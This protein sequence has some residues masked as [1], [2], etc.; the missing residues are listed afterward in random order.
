M[1]EH[2]LA[3]RIEQLEADNA[4]LRHLLARQDVGMELRHQVRNTLATVRA[5]IRRSAEIDGTVDDYAAHLEGRLDAILRV[6]GTM[7]RGAIEG[8]DLYGL[9]SSELLA[10]LAQDGKQVRIE[11]PRLHLQ[12][13][14]AEPLC[15]AF[16]EL[17]T[18][19]VKFGVLGVPD[20]H[21]DVIWGV[22][23]AGGP[24]PTLEFTWV[25][26]G[27]PAIEAA[28]PR[29]GFGT[30]QLELMLSY[31]LGAKTDLTFDPEGLRCRIRLPLSPDI[32][33]L[34]PTPRHEGDD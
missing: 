13:K 18:N 34:L 15:L 3:A 16:H 1:S 22:I 8:A 28:P 26:S 4:R 20:G 31:Q 7:T 27:G 14:A 12:P 32:G 6:Q 33:S 29:R 5:V 24:S 11:G 19:S 30:E 21:I 23:D 9:L 25:E 2:S 10:C 17:A